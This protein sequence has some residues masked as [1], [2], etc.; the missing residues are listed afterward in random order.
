MSAYL[1]PRFSEA[2]IEF[3]AAAQ[4]W[5]RHPERLA[6]EPQALAAYL[7]QLEIEGFA[8]QAATNHVELIE[9]DR[10]LASLNRHPIQLQEFLLAVA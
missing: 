5:L 6:P 7:A 8:T 1:E 3:R 9:R 2:G 4:D 10:L